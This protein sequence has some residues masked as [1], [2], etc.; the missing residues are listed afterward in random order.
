[1]M[2]LAFGPEDV[3]LSK[4]D[5]AKTILGFLSQNNFSVSSQN[6]SLQ[7]LGFTPQTYPDSIGEDYS[8]SVQ[9]QLFNLEEKMEPSSSVGNHYFHQDSS[10]NGSLSS[11]TSRRSPSLL[12]FPIKTCH[13]FNK[14]FCKH[15][16]NCRYFHGHYQAFGSH[17]NEFQSE[18]NG[19]TPEYLEKLEMEIA[20]L[21]KSHGG[22]PVSISLL[23]MLYYKKYGR[24]LRADGY[25]TKLLSCFSNSILLI[26]RPRGQH[27]MILTEDAPK[28]LECLHERSEQ[29]STSAG[30]HQ[31]Y[32]TFPADS[33]FSEDD[34]SSYFKQF[35]PVKDVRIPCQEKR[36]YGFVRFLYPETVCHI[37]MKKNAHYIGGSRVLV[38]PYKEK[39][40]MVDRSYI[41][42][43]KLSMHHPCQYLDLDSE[44]FGI[45]RNA[46]IA[47][48]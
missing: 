33:T 48:G 36:M 40:R 3:L 17:L 25:L 12:E 31:I 14:G 44:L 38:K 35:G 16:E 43:N 6:H 29:G 11:S 9:S 45:T 21:L 10:F 22:A 23:P 1:M 26:N 28:Y 34:I 2:K 30:S 8:F 27:S 32:L 20:E 41:G 47:Q 37:L 42:K 24:I 7:N 39:S 13:Y 15:G 18:E 19:F 4:I 5:E 46:P